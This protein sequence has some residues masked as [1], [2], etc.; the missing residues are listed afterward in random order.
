MWL[1]CSS[2]EAPTA[3]AS[4]GSAGAAGKA[5]KAGAGGKASAGAPSAGSAGASAGGAGAAGSPGAAGGAGSAGGAGAGPK[6]CTGR[7]LPPSIPPDWLEWTGWSCECSLYYPPDGPSALPSLTWEP[8]GDAVP[9]GVDCRR[10]S[11]TAFGDAR[12]IRTR[13]ALDSSTGHSLVQLAVEGQTPKD[14]SNTFYL[15]LDVDTDRP[16]SVMSQP[17]MLDCGRKT[18]LD[19]Q[20]LLG[21]VAGGRQIVY[22]PERGEWANAEEGWVGVTFAPGE[23]PT[24]GAR[25]P[26]QTKLFSTTWLASQAGVFEWHVGK[27]LFAPWGGA[28]VPVLKSSDDA[29]GQPP[30][31]LMPLPNGHALLEVGGNV[32]RGVWAWSEASGAVPILRKFGDTTQGD[33][34]VGSDGKDIVWVRG[35][36]KPPGVEAPYTKLDVM[37]APYSLDPAAVQATARRLKAGNDDYFPK[38]YVV[39]CGYAA[40]ALSPIV[41]GGDFN[42]VDLALTNISAIRHR[43]VE[44][45]EFQSG[46]PG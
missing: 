18:L 9:P 34:G 24:V 19:G 11:Y 26:V 39:G 32:T 21:G 44:L 37:T 29:D 45:R 10:A 17:S 35:T 38:R 1:A 36:G 41:G 33:G 12:V 7:P 3:S 16:L 23:A 13:A 27:M 46:H 22:R 31:G 2:S 28:T 42:G 4:A 43:L 15:A 14:D 40:R 6:T 20:F 8:W 25:I 30:V 5:G